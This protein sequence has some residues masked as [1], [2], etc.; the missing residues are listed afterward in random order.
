[1]PGFHSP[2]NCYTTIQ[3]FVT[4]EVAALRRDVI[5][6]KGNDRTPKAFLT[7]GMVQ[8]HY[9]DHAQAISL[10]GLKPTIRGD[11]EYA[12]KVFPN[13]ASLYNLAVLNAPGDPNESKAG[14]MYKELTDSMTII[15]NLHRTRSN[16][17]SESS[18]EGED[19]SPPSGESDTATKSKKKIDPLKEGISD[20]M[21][22]KQK[23]DPCQR[24]KNHIGPAATRSA[25]TLLVQSH[26]SKLC[27]SVFNNKYEYRGVE[28]DRVL[29]HD[30][31]IGG[32]SGS[33]L[34]RITAIPFEFFGTAKGMHSMHRKEG[35]LEPRTVADICMLVFGENFRESLDENKKNEYRRLQRGLVRTCRPTYNE[36]DEENEDYTL[37]LED[38]Q[39]ITYED[40]EDGSPKTAKKMTPRQ[41]GI[42]TAMQVL[43]MVKSLVNDDEQVPHRLKKFVENDQYTEAVQ[44]LNTM[45]RGATRGDDDDDDD[46][47][48]SLS[49]INFTPELSK[50][51]RNYEK[52]MNTANKRLED[53]ED[54]EMD[55]T[56]KRLKYSEESAKK[57]RK[58]G[59]K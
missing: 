18:G 22:N 53:S 6:E 38:R 5:A 20:A 52:I 34:K 25:L 9:R 39:V 55:T 30:R 57:R 47:I 12:S 49:D 51:K 33:S 4:Y 3:C 36:G 59:N 50:H 46:D 23:F 27:Q 43:V 29:T 45:N 56:K 11:A 14:E 10:Y 19:E 24:Q 44:A 16:D 28:A 7:Y 2:G 42:Q 8:G 31:Y 48:V 58:S 37:D 41:K 54:E 15:A 17:N 32:L 13:F 1:M 35:T 21:K 40:E 26:Y